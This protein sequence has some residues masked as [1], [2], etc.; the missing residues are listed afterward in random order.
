[1][2]RPRPFR[3]VREDVEW[4]EAPS[5]DDALGAAETL[6]G[7]EGGEFTVLRPDGLAIAWARSVA[8]PMPPDGE[9]CERVHVQILQ[10]NRGGTP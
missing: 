3:I 1:M 5:I 8:E 6:A 9:L 2:S 4:A 7:E 10:G